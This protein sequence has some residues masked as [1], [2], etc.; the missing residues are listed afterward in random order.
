MWRVAFYPHPLNP[1]P[2]R[3]GEGD[4]NA[5][6]LDILLRIGLFLS[7]DQAKGKK[8][9]LESPPTLS[10]FNSNRQTAENAKNLSGSLML[11]KK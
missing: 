6:F 3:N 9:T 10:K 8:T 2:H 1:P 7:M 11:F 4:F 5:A